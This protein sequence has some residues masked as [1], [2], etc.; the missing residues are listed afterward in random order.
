MLRTRPTA[1]HRH[2]NG[3]RPRA[4]CAA[5]RCQATGTHL[6]VEPT[7]P[8]WLC[9]THFDVWVELRKGHVRQIVD[10]IRWR[11]HQHAR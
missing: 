1:R 2:V 3:D 6:V 9:G 5:R 7:G 8:A 11:L 10:T 4:G